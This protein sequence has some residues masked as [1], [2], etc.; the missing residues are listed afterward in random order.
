MGRNTPSK[1]CDSTTSRLQMP[2]R[3]LGHSVHGLGATNASLSLTQLTI[4]AMSF[5][6]VSLAR[7]YFP[8]SASEAPSS[9]QGG[10]RASMQPPCRRKGY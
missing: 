10:V 4:A 1:Y 2:R 7:A 8:G 6:F 9:D 5:G 3:V